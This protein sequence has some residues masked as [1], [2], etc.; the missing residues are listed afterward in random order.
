MR[1]FRNMWNYI[2]LTR[3]S[4]KR[5]HRTCVLVEVVTET[6]AVY[7]VYCETFWI[8]IYPNV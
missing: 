6:A 5:R 1:I 4:G 2:D 7:P 8:I 3:Y